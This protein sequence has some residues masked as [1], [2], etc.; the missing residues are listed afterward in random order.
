MN[1]VNK[2]TV[3]HLI[4]NKRRT[5]IT[6]IGVIISVAMV[7]AVATSVFSF[8]DLMKR[9]TIARDGEWHVQY[10]KVTVDQVNELE[11]DEQTKKLAL[12]NDVGYASL[13]NAQNKYKPYI[14]IKQYNDTANNLFPIEL[15]KGRLPEKEN[16]IVLSVEIEK[17][18]NTEYSIGDQLTLDIGDRYTDSSPVPL[19]QT[20]TLEMGED[21]VNETLITKQTETYTIVGF[22]NQPL[23]EKSWSPGHTAITYLDK[24][25]LKSDEKVNAVIQLKDVNYNLYNH[26]EELASKLGIKTF[27]YNSELLR[28]SAIT[29]NSD[30]A[31]TLFS[32]IAI[33]IA[34]IMT[35][36]VS[37]IYNA[38]AISVSERSRHLGMLSSVGATKKQKRNSVFFEGIVIGTISI[39]IGIIAGIGGIGLTFHFINTFIG[40]TFGIQE[41]LIVIVTPL[42]IIV[43]CIISIVTIFIS[44]FVPAKKASKISAIDAI[45]QTE[46]IK[47]TKKAVKTSK[48]VRKLFGIEAD[49]GLKNMK[50]NKRR[51]QATIF[52][53]IISIVLFLT[54]SFFTGSIQKSLDMSQDQANFDIQIYGEDLTVKDF[55]PFRT[56]KEVTDSTIYNVVSAYSS[57]GP[58]EMPD[59]LLEL[60][61]TTDD[62]NLED[63]KY[64]YYL[65]IYGMDEASFHKYAKQIG[66]NPEKLTSSKEPQAIIINEVTYEDAATRKFIETKTIETKVGSSIDL[67]SMNYET[68]EKKLMS[69]VQVG[70][71]TDQVPVGINH[72]R[73]GGLDII[74]SDKTLEQILDEELKEELQTFFFMNTTDPEKTQREIEEL[75]KSNMEVYNVSRERKD[76][77]QTML[78]MSIFIYGFI[79]LISF[80]SIA[81]IFNTI[82]TSIA[83]RKREFAML[84]SVGMTPKGFNKMLHYESI[85]Y[86]VKGLLYGLPLSLLVMVLIYFSM[87][88][89]F[90]Y[91][92]TLHWGSIIFVII[93]IFII[94]GSA[95]LYSSSKVKKENIIDGLKQENI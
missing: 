19:T 90:E 70:A 11:K 80:I 21:T 12:S 35:G 81:N 64:P 54:V 3:R 83:L 47:L 91:G 69:K 29:N 44:T 45:R 53:L 25:S 8:L 46:D 48:L 37:L 49:I 41:K 39:P 27:H 87:Q 5:L 84:K 65:S 94:V 62:Y 57:I 78:L 51:Y 40:N 79:V 9:D 88:N 50:R 95:M 28:Y 18:T 52:S 89:T 6:I 86:G 67:Y 75:K 55:S 43:P 76:A 17:D 31:K 13:E 10:Q 56:L 23:W 30:L 63:G 26:A 82:T 20:D 14:F 16:E 93:A 85:F 66:V 59:R 61:E 7:S 22:I 4:E 34:I 15:T 71:L 77:E 60:V 72:S 33:I 92:F 1:I 74:V 42:S 68:N 58:E 24:K 32:L 2:L 36:S 38:F 73:L